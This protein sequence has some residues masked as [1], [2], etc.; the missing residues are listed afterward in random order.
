MNQAQRTLLD[1]CVTAVL[2]LIK[3]RASRKDAESDNLTALTD[4]LHVLAHLQ[5]SEETNALVQV[6]LDRDTPTLA[7]T[8]RVNTTLDVTRR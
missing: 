4:T 7:P 3:L 1:E 2:D 8:D 6:D 5:T